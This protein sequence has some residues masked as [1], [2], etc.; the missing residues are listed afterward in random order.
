MGDTPVR[1]KLGAAKAQSDGC[2]RSGR[3]KSAQKAAKSDA[4]T[5]AKA[6]AKGG[7]LPFSTAPALARPR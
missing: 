1:F 7:T 2:R 5:A 4:K 3:E 6:L